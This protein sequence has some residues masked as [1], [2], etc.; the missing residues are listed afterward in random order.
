M[1]LA[2]WRPQFRRGER[3]ATAGLIIY[4]THR[5]DSSGAPLKS[6]VK[7]TRCNTLNWCPRIKGCLLKLCIKSKQ[8][9]ERA[10]QNALYEDQI[11]QLAGYS[12]LSSA[13]SKQV[14]NSI[15]TTES[16]K[17][18]VRPLFECSKYCFHSANIC[19]ILSPPSLQNCSWLN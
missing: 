15:G 7:R 13:F 9:R 14:F 2:T 11:Q 17:Y 12:G 1:L 6:S 4:F 18:C 5:P 3:T 16:S 8:K 19:N 10:M